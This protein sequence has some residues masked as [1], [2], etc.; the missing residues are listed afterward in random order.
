MVLLE[1]VLENVLELVVVEDE[2]VLTV[3]WVVVLESVV[4]ELDVLELVVVIVVLVVEE[5]DKCFSK[6]TSSV[7]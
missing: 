6:L 4:V 7:G 2:L 5:V 3:V 1:V